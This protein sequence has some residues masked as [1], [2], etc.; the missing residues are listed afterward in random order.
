MVDFQ[1]LVDPYPR[2]HLLMVEMVTCDAFLESQ[3]KR[4]EVR[5]YL[6]AIPDIGLDSNVSMYADVKRGYKND[7]EKLLND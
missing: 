1:G 4:L 3:V 6:K 5:V 7:L 2:A